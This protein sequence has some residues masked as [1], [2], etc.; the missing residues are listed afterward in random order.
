MSVSGF[1]IDVLDVDAR[2]VNG[3]L[4]GQRPMPAAIRALCMLI[5]ERP[6]LAQELAK[7]RQPS[8]EP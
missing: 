2:K 1:A 7:A 6:A 5:M 4:T 3:W 8:G